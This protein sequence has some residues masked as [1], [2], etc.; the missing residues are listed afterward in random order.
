MADEKKPKSEQKP[1]PEKSGGAQKS[2]GRKAKG[3]EAAAHEAATVTSTVEAVPAR[4]FERY[5]QQVVPALTKQFNYKNPMQV[6][7]LQKIVV[8]MGLGAAVANPKIIDTAV[9][10]LKA[11]SGQKPVVTRAKKAIATFKI[12]EGLAIGAK[13][14]LRGDIMYEF[15]D[16]LITMALP[17]VRDFRGISGKGFDGRGNFAMGMKEQIVFPEIVYDRVDAIRGMDIVF[18]TSAQTDA[19]AKALLK[20]FDLPFAN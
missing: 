8:N 9:E 6:P 15:I 7:R 12:R 5:K 16:R 1:R 19:E 10:D 18:V 14:T 13:V 11:I 20:H 3:A 17:R 4:L 2:G